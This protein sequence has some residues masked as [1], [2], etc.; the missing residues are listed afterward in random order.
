MSSLL[1]V[2]EIA[3]YS[4]AGVTVSS[5]LTA[6]ST[7]AV[8]GATT[9]TGAATLSSTL[10][11]TG[12]STFSAALRAADGS[13]ALPA[14]SFTND[15]DTGFYSLGSDQVVV[16]T[17]N[18]AEARFDIDFFTISRDSSFGWSTTDATAA[19][20]L[21]LYRD[22]A[23]TLAQRNGTNAQTLRLYNT[24]TDAS[25]YERFNVLWSGNE[26]FLT[27]Q[28]AG[29]GT[30]RTIYFGTIGAS[31]AAILTNNI[32][33]FYWDSSGNFLANADNSY[34][35]GA[36]GATRP[37]TGYFGTSVVAP[38][39]GTNTDTAFIIKANSLTSWQFGASADGYNITPAQNNGQ[40]IGSA[41]N[42]IKSGYF[43]TSVLTPLVGS[44]AAS[45]LSFTTTGGTQL[46][47][48]HIASAVNYWQFTGSAIGN[49]IGGTAQGS[50][51]DIGLYFSAKGANHIDFYTAA[52]G[53][54]QV[55][56]QHTASATRHLV[57]TGSNGGNPTISTSAGDL[58]ITP[59]IV[60]GS[61]I[62]ALTGFG[63]N[64]AAVQT[65]YASGG[66][67]NAYSTGAFGL[68]SDANM[69]AMHALVVAMRAA[70]VAN[71]IMS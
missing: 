10:A 18:F 43:G 32:T 2:D 68:N 53:A 31:P 15:S 44:N 28:S 64:G 63:C 56:V 45:N 11:V 29:T 71:G 4:A 12:I 14:Y 1:K 69:S 22:A 36:S 55:R 52:V 3:L 59:A 23:N 46:V 62:K 42:N 27:G 60:G 7:L 41:T 66:A 25:N 50:D 58:A 33:R 19:S 8:T 54:L 61:S 38:N 39:I 65:A 70:L 21:T 49:F 34:D 9:L 17:G 37:R 57:F 5:A 6:S 51:T 67:L 24:Y 48:A 35:I 16:T 26:L 47:V 20:D 40:D 30:S 13:V